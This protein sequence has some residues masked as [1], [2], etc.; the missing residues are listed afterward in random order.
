MTA[1]TAAPRSV[2]RPEW[3]AALRQVSVERPMLGGRV[4]I[5]I[6]TTAEA[7]PQARAMATRTLDRIEA[8]AA[9]LTRFDPESD[10]S[11][12]NADPAASVR[13]RPT[14][15]AVLDAGRAAESAT[16]GIVNIALLDARLAAEGLPARGAAA[17]GVAARRWSLARGARS[18]SVERPAG[19]RFDLDG[20]A[21]G[22]LADRA[23]ERIRG[24][25]VTVVDADG[26]LAI[27]VA[28]GASCIV[29]V[30]DPWNGHP[31]AIVLRLDAER[32]AGPTRYGVATSGISN[33]AWRIDDVVTHHLIDPRTDDPAVTDLIQATVIAR[34][35]RRAEAFAKAA[36]ILGSEA[37]QDVLA[38]SDILGAVLMTRDGAQVVT[39]GTTRF[40]A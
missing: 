37:A 2:A 36:V 20:V 10:L 8:W 23:L 16:G 13:V 21:K 33:H 15:A 5:H 28:P 19:L 3:P 38:S 32:D 7:S 34:T 14:L 39:S 27:E 29:G 30:E 31:D 35:A 12:L 40:L 6:T 22:W 17:A 18:T 24:Q 9:L 1:A 11:R 26:D 4:G 25:Q